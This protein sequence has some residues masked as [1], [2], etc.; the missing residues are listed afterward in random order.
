MSFPRLVDIAFAARP[1]TI[2]QL[3][4]EDLS[5]RSDRKAWHKLNHLGLLVARQPLFAPVHQLR[6]AYGAGLFADYERG[7]RLAPLL[8]RIAHDGD[9]G[10]PGVIA[11]DPL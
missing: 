10:H 11:Q 7:H 9:L 3:T 5:C 4:L 1:E 2:P 6:L 8:V